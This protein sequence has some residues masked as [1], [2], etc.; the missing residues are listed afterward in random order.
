MVFLLSKKRISFIVTVSFLEE[1]PNT[2][3]HTHTYILLFHYQGDHSSFYKVCLETLLGILGIRNF[4][5]LTNDCSFLC[6]LICMLVFSVDINKD[7]FCHDMVC[8]CFFSSIKIIKSQWPHLDIIS[9]GIII[10]QTSVG[11]SC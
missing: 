9:F 11:K 3:P 7:I 8:I 10:I 1:T 5:S 4:F 2:H 6:V